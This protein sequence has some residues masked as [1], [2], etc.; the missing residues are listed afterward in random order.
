MSARSLAF[1]ITMDYYQLYGIRG[2]AILSGFQHRDYIIT[3]A[4]NP[5]LTPKFHEKKCLHE[6]Y[7]I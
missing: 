6:L 2:W 7:I 4:E 5:G 1:L 3:V